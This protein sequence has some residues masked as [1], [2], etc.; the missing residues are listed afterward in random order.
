MKAPQGD[1]AAD[2]GI[3]TALGGGFDFLRTPDHLDDGGGRFYGS[4]FREGL[5]HVGQSAR[6]PC[7]PVLVHRLEA[8]LQTA[9]RLLR[10]RLAVGPE[11]DV[12]D[13]AENV[14]VLMVLLQ[15]AGARGERE[16]EKEQQAQGGSAFHQVRKHNKAR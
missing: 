4:T 12:H 7:V 15:L 13:G 10:L 8:G 9:E 6:L 5:V 16:G 1:Q 3:E 11:R 2:G 14:E